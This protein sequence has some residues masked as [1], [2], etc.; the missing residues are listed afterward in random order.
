MFALGCTSPFVGESQPKTL[1]EKPNTLIQEQDNSSLNKIEGFKSITPGIITDISSNG[2]NI[3]LLKQND[4]DADD[5]SSEDSIVYN[6]FSYN[7]KNEEIQSIVSSKSNIIS[8]KLDTKEEG[9]YYIENKSESLYGLFWIDT[10]GDKKISISPSEHLLNPNFH[11]T[12]NNTIYYGT[13]DGKI[14]H[15]DKDQI[16]FTIEM[17]P[18]Y[19]IQQIYY[20]KKKDLIFLSAYK[21]DALNLYSINSKA[22]ELTLLIP[23]IV[24]DFKISNDGKKVLYTSTMP[25]SNKRILCILELESGEIT[26]I[27]EGY[28]QE[29]SFSPQ[30]DQIAYLERVDSNSDM[31]NLWVYNFE[32]AKPKKLASNLK[33]SSKIYWHPR[34]NKLFFSIYDTIE[35]Q[36]TSNIYSLN[37]TQ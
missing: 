12:P 37:F 15:T 34:E 33:A 30:G 17:D 27:V 24:G 11:I 13:K 4:I 7:L 16:L 14:V 35:G 25:D 29:P 31:Q 10:N 3:I 20:N 19:D 6:M 21:D 32:T 2:D 1:Q 18:S 22:E 5:T 28:I 26:K 23:N 9:F 8:S 36:L